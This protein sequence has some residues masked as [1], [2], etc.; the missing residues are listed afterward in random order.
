MVVPRNEVEIPGATDAMTG[1]LKAI[2]GELQSISQRLLLESVESS[3][4]A[5][6]DFPEPL[7]LMSAESPEETEN[8][9][10]SRS[11]HTADEN[12]SGT[13]CGNCGDFCNPLDDNSHVEINITAAIINDDSIDR[14]KN[15][16]KE[17]LSDKPSITYNY[18]SII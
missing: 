4:R 6:T 3:R 7:S 14:L 12:D 1:S 16:V 2:V 18:C 9:E 10:P 15:L 11:D 5:R 17:V 8:A 13:H